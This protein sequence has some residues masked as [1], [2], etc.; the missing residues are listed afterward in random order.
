[1]NEK[2]LVPS[3]RFTGFTDAWERCK[4]GDLGKVRSGIGFPDAEQGG[5]EGLPFLK[6]PI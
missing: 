1:M 6:F 2:S 4:L 5:T 3:I